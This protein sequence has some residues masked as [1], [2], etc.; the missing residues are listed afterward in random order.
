MEEIE[1]L[2]ERL[3]GL[4]QGFH[5]NRLEGNPPTRAEYEKLRAWIVQGLLDV[6]IVALL[7]AEVKARYPVQY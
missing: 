7:N 4:N 2:E 3:Y 6:E 5:S 1:A